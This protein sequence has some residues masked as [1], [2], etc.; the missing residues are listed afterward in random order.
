M[1]DNDFD[2]FSDIWTSAYEAVSRGKTPSAGATNIAFEALREFPLPQISAALTR[3]V[4]DPDAGRFGLTP[5]DVVVQIKGGK[6]NVDQIIDA[7]RDPSTPLAVLCRI[8]ITSWELDNRTRYELGSFA[9]GC[10]AKLP[11]WEQR[12][13]A[14]EL[15][16]HELERMEHYGV[17]P[18]VTK[19][20]ALPGTRQAQLTEK[21]NANV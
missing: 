18:T 8:K 12:I 21:G 20:I 13:A 9:E 1:N 15:T 14:G 19:L 7:A 16:K 10:I 11:E 6:P 3:H 5:A 4:R 17:D 2:T